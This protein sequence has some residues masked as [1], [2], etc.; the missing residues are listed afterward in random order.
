MRGQY[1]NTLEPIRE[2]N[3][4]GD[5]TPLGDAEDEEEEDEEVQQADVPVPGTTT[6][7]A[8]PQPS[9][10]K[11]PSSLLT[12]QMSAYEGMQQQQAEPQE[13]AASKGLGFA[14]HSA[15]NDIVSASFH[16]NQ[17]N[18]T[19]SSTSSAAMAPH[20]SNVASNMDALS[21]DTNGSSKASKTV[22]FSQTNQTIE[23]DNTIRASSVSLAIH[24]ALAIGRE[25]EAA[26]TDGSAMIPA[27]RPKAIPL[28]PDSTPAEVVSSNAPTSSRPG[29]NAN[30]HVEMSNLVH[31]SSASLLANGSCRVMSVSGRLSY[32]PSSGES[33][34]HDHDLTADD[35]Q[36]ELTDKAVVVIRRVRDKLTGLDF[37]EASVGCGVQAL[38]VPEQVERLIKEATSNE[39]LSQ[40]FF[41]WCPYW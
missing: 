40:S 13:A 39:N 37:P 35:Q 21:G 10:A 8:P 11:L 16:R 1:I 33:G 25:A 28:P 41:G 36:Q 31:S 32:L 12:S 27:P 24:P 38:A 19:S 14:E 5:A 17:L 29:L 20:H 30:L 9:P 26:G 23:A 2:L 15:A 22:S 6:S 7:A 34:V 3:Q 4:A 18:C